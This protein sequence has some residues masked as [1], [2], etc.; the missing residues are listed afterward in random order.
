METTQKRLFSFFVSKDQFAEIK[1]R[2]AEHG[3][4]VAEEL[5]RL[6]EVALKKAKEE[7]NDE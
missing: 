6:I 7:K 2:A 4:S 3:V 1:R 5:R